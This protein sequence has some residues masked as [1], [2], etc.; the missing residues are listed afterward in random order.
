M[1]NLPSKYPPPFFFWR[2]RSHTSDSSSPPAT[3]LPEVLN[4]KNWL[5]Y[6]LPF[7][8]CQCGFCAHHCHVQVQITACRHMWKGGAKQHLRSKAS[9]G[10]QCLTRCLL[11]L[12]WWPWCFIIFLISTFV[13]SNSQSLILKLPPAKWWHS[14][15][16]TW[17]CIK[18]CPQCL[19]SCCF[20]W[21]YKYSLGSYE[22]F[23]VLSD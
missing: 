20:V 17:V 22:G 6:F 7:T 13:K 5:D 12:W 11:C 2:F 21:E 16:A 8:S 19:F 18:C 1:P 3:P 15:P 14:V 4:K 23:V 9:V 10:F